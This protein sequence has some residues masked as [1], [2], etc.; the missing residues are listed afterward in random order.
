M[1]QSVLAYQFVSG[2]R[3]EIKAKVAGTEGDFEK[4]L[5]KARFEE[6]KLRDIGD[7]SSKGTPKKPFVTPNVTRPRDGLTPFRDSRGSPGKGT[8]DLD[9]NQGRPANRCF[10]CG[11]GGHFAR[12]CPHRGKA[13]PSE[14]PGRSQGSNRPTVAQIGSNNPA[15]NSSSEGPE[16]IAELHCQLQEAELKEALTKTSATMHV[17]QSTGT[18]KGAQLGPTLTA[19]VELEGSSTQALLDTGLPVT[20]VSLQFLLEAIA[21]QR[22]K[23]QSPDDWRAA[24]EKRLEPSTVTLQNYGVQRLGIVRQIKVGIARPG[25]SV[26]AVIQVHQDAPT[27]LLIGTDLLPQLGFTFL[28]TEFEGE[29]VDLLRKPSLNERRNTQHTYADV[30]RPRTPSQGGGGGKCDNKDFSC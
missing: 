8:R 14:T 11:S 23:S 16:R 12:Q 7:P 9:G 20:I 6:V 30:V 5:T 29:D 13:K 18:S 19:D 21:R 1:G 24:V 22:P 17:I 27:N 10:N 2:L 4:L 3:P 15:H 25:C 28:Q 26:E